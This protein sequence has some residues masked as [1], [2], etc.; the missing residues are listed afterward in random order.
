MLWRKKN[1]I[2][3]FK[4]MMVF[5]GF[6]LAS[7][8]FLF[9]SSHWTLEM[10]CFIDVSLVHVCCVYRLMYSRQYDI[11]ATQWTLF[12]IITRIKHVLHEPCNFILDVFIVFLI[13]FIVSDFVYSCYWAL[14]ALDTLFSVFIQKKH[15]KITIGYACARQISRL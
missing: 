9:L 15:D 13:H 7:R 5:V 10:C 3:I 12:W 14:F 1:Y 6:L 2:N 8:L 4:R 11:I